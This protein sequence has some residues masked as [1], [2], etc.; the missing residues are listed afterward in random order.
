MTLKPSEVAGRIGRVGR[1]EHRGMYVQVEAD[2]RT[3]AWHLWLLSR[4][5]ELG[6]SEGWDIWADTWEDV[7]GWLSP[8]ELDVT[9]L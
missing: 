8:S 5:P 1:G 4:N 6:P 2:E 3:S 9:W 7:L